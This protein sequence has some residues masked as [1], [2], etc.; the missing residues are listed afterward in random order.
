MQGQIKESMT[1]AQ[2]LP[3]ADEPNGV[4]HIDVDIAPLQLQLLHWFI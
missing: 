3:L 4:A 2:T 1:R